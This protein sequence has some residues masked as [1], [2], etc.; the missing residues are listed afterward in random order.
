MWHRDVPRWVLETIYFGIKRSKVKVTTRKNIAGVGLSTL[1]SA[2]FFIVFAMGARALYEC[3]WIKM[4][5]LEFLNRTPARGKSKLTWLNDRIS[6]TW[7][8]AEKSGCAAEVLPG[9][10]W[11]CGGVLSEDRIQLFRPSHAVK[12]LGSWQQISKQWRVMRYR[13]H[14]QWRFYVSWVTRRTSGT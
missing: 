12:D 3:R 14:I 9:E 5:W 1:V 2:G 10:R 7:I 11:V 8:V 13:R 6:N 4:R